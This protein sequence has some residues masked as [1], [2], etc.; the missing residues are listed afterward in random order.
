MIKTPSVFLSGILLA[1]Q[2]DAGDSRRDQD[3]TDL[4]PNEMPD[5]N[6]DQNTTQ[7][8]YS[9]TFLFL[10]IKLYYIQIV[11]NNNCTSIKLEGRRPL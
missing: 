9:L 7:P 3:T 10:F 11:K 5:E 4:D 1:A 6:T 8:P 2:A